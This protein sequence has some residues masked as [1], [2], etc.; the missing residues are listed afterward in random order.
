[1]G[2]GAAKPPFRQAQSLRLPEA[3]F[4]TSAGRGEYQSSREGLDQQG[5]SLVRWRRHG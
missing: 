1:M 3:M 5:P 4:A 2:G